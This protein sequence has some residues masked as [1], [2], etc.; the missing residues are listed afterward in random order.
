MNWKIIGM[1]ATVAGGVLTLI[2]NKADEE[3]MKEE[4]RKEVKEQLS[5]KES[6]ES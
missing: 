5:L 6:K 3:K 4:I 1:L 2:S